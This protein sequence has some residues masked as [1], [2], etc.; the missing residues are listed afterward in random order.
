M[1]E[2]ADLLLH[3]AGQ[4]CVIPPH[5]NGPQRGQALGDLGII[6]DGALAIRD[7]RI[8]AVGLS[9]DLRR[10]FREPPVPGH[11]A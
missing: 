5:K 2:P 7:G 4:L 9:T 10:R 6:A 11:E 3:S 1:T 8:L